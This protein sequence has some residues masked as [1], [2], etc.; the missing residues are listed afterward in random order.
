M[1][2]QSFYRKYRPVVFDE[3]KGQDHVTRTLRNAIVT[4]KISHAYLFAGSRG[5]GKTSVAKLLAKALNCV[6]GPTADPC[7]KCESCIAIGAGTSLDVVEMDAASNRGIDDIRDI[8]D[9][10]A[11]S[12]VEGKSKV[13]ILDEAHML[14]KEASNA[15]LKVLEEPPP[16]V[17]FVLC[18]TEAHK[19]LPTIQ[20]RC[21]RFE[22]RRPNADMVL[23]VLDR[24][25]AEEQLD[26]EKAGLE[27]I[28]RAAAG[29]F[30]DA[31]GVLDQL[32]TYCEGEI[33]LTDVLSLLGTVE[34]ELLFEAVDIV[35]ETDPRGAL[36]F[37]N[38]L[39]EGGK[40]FG[41]FAGELVGHLRN[42]FL[43]QRLDEY[44]AGIINVSADDLSRLKAQARMLTEAQV[45]RFLELLTGAQAAI[46]QG[47]DPRLQLE[48]AFIAMASPAVDR[49]EKSILYRLDQLERQVA[50]GG[51][52]GKASP[53]AA[54]TDTHG[55]AD[56]E[57]ETE[58]DEI[59]ESTEPEESK[60]VIQ[61]SLDR[62]QRAWSIILSQVKKKKVPLHSL[63]Q[64]ARPVDL[65]GKT[66]V[67]GFA[68]GAE[69]HKNQVEKQDNVSV[70]TGVLRD[71]TGDD[72][73]VRCT[74]S[75]G[76]RPA[77]EKVPSH[78]EIIA[79]AKK[80]FSAEEVEP[81]PRDGGGSGDNV[82][83]GA[84]PE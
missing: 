24:V 42:V 60:P 6:D 17:I 65:D 58:T 82:P 77:Q 31:I 47:D 22:F 26:I 64:E 13:Y 49:S 36:L 62:I 78:E 68:P 16:H 9:K 59:R 34:S 41:Q 5:T 33:K 39:S 10:V 14:T 32:A 54:G 7:G 73:R 57:V 30:R 20:S 69:F 11:F 19:V 50:E 21:Q 45:F 67:I 52:A 4:G 23:E 81:A 70:L 38:R 15:F 48:L 3:V 72:L 74:I 28:A 55:E 40:D 56:T 46:K 71:M 51:I 76:A 29:S 53:A 8:R 75:E 43:F 79:M 44:P 12:P 25:T 83:P 2:H 66:L 63:L 84:A 27:A 1:T 18:T 37:I 80:A 61:L 35:A